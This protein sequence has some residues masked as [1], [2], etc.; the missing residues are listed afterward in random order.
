MNECSI[1]EKSRP[2][3][4]K[5][6]CCQ[7][8][9]ENGEYLCKKCI[10]KVEKCPFCRSEKQKTDGSLDEIAEL[11]LFDKWL[12]MTYHLALRVYI[13][14]TLKLV[15]N[16]DDTILPFDYNLNLDSMLDVNPYMI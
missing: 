15:D 3:L 1:C 4:I 2:K 16:I 7:R 6:Q 13:F 11:I 8:S 14:D 9:C 5:P 12:E 10:D